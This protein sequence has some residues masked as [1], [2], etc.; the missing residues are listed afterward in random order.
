[1][2]TNVHFS[3]SKKFTISLLSVHINIEQRKFN[4]PSSPYCRQRSLQVFLVTLQDA[5]A[6]P[7]SLSCKHP[8]PVHQG[9]YTHYY[10]SYCKLTPVILLSLCTAH[11]KPTIFSVDPLRRSYCAHI[12]SFQTCS[13]HILDLDSSPPIQPLQP[14]QG[15]RRR[16]AKQTR[17]T[18][19]REKDLR[20]DRCPASMGLDTVMSRFV[21]SIQSGGVWS[22]Y[23]YG[24]LDDFV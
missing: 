7:W 1:M 8:L 13:S 15:H 14:N 5:F 17:S 2:W 18:H 24:V 4:R 21:G 20:E 11:A 3:P 12:F 10:H 22:E 19:S 23:R 16:Y 9:R 6:I